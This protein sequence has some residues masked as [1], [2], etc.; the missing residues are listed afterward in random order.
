MGRPSDLEAG[1]GRF[2]SWCAQVTFFGHVGRVF[3]W[4]FTYVGTCLGTFF[5]WGGVTFWSGRGHFFV[6]FGMSWDVSGSGRGTFSDGFGMVLKKNVGWGRK[7]KIFKNGRE[8][9]C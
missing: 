3:L 9:F 6:K 5:W 4:I 7:M 2:D 1:G 8:Y